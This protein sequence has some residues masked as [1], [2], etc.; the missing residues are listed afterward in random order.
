[1]TVHLLLFNEIIS[2]AY[3]SSR[4]D[5]KKDASHCVSCADMAGSRH[6]I[7][8]HDSHSHMC[9]SHSMLSSVVDQN[10]MF[11]FFFFFFFRTG[12]KECC[13]RRVRE[14]STI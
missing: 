4:K 6:A 1:M 7:F 10:I 8:A 13:V 9:A 5:Q 11:H 12:L 2:F 14:T 3:V